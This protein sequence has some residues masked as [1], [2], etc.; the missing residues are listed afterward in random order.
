VKWK[1]IVAWIGGGIGVLILL[2]VCAAYLIQQNTFLHRY[3][4]GKMI[5]IARKSSGAEIQMRDYAIR[6]VPLHITL[7]DVSVRGTEKNPFRPLASLPRIE[8]GISWRALWHQNVDLTELILD[9]PTINLITDQSGNSNLPIRPA[10]SGPSTSKLQVSIEHAVVRNGELRYNDSPRKIDADLAEFHAGVSHSTGTD[11]YTG[12]LG[13]NRG[14]IAVDGYTPVRHATDLSF[15]ATNAGITFD[16]IHLSTGRSQLSVRGA[17]RGYSSPIVEGQYEALLSTADLRE[18][19][20]SLP[21]SGGEIDLAGSVSYRAVAGAPLNSLKLSGHVA[22]KTLMA[23]VSGTKVKFQSL[24]GNYALENGTLR[25]TGLQTETMGGTLRAELTGERLTGTPRYQL[26]LS[27]DSVSLEQAGQ[28]A[29]GTEFPLRG[30]VQLHANAHWTA[31]VATMM[32]RADARIS[33]TLNEPT[34]KA[35][36]PNATASQNATSLPVNA[37]VHVAYDAP[38]AT[39]TVT[40]SSFSSRQTSLIADGTVSDHSALSIRARTS[41]LREV[42]LLLSSAGDIQSAAAKTSPS[43]SNPLELRGRASLEAQIRGRIQDPRITGHAQADDIEVHRANWPH[44]ESNFEMTSASASL[45]NG[46]ARISNQGRLNFSLTTSLQNWSYSANNP[47]TAQIQASQVPLADVEQLAGSS[48]PVSGMLS[49]S[50]SVHGTLDDP[51][52]EGFIQLRDASLWGEPVR[53]VSAQIHAADKSLSATFNIATAAGNI[54]GNGEFGAA[55]RHYQISISHSVLNL[56]QIRYL[57]SHG[58]TM[59]GTLGIEAQGQGTLKSPELQAALTGD[60][61]ALGGTALGSLNAQFHVANERANFALTSNMAG[62]QIHAN[63]DAGLAAP[64][65][66]HG[67]FEIRSLQFGPLLAAYLPSI[68]RPFQGNAEVR[69]QID[70]PLADPGQ[71]KASVELSTL[72]LAYQDL[73]LASAG[74]VRFQYANDVVTISQAELRGTDTDFKF[75]GKLPL[76]GAA[77]LEI[78][79]SG[80]IDLRLLT[81]LGSNTQSSGTVKID[82]TAKGALKQPQLG[83]SIEIV[84]ASF[85][86]DVVPV[87]V[88]NLNARI[89]IAKSRLTIENLSGQMSGGSFSVSGFAGYSPAS[90]SLQVSGKSIRVRYPEGTR[91]QLDTNITLIGTPASSVLNGRVTVDGLSFTPDFDLAN[92]IGQFSSSTPSA[93]SQW[94]KNMRIDIAVV[95]SQELALSSSKLSLQGSADLRVA[96]TLANPV[97]LGR[98]ILSGGE[99]FFMGNRYQVQSG[100]VVFANPIRTEPTLNLYVTTQV[101]DYNITLNFLGPVDRLRTNYMSEPALP[102]VDIIHLLAFGKTTAQSAATATPAALGAESAI[103]NGLTSQVSSRIEKLAGISQL[104]I[105]PSLGGDNSNPGARVAIQQR[106][107]STIL[108]TFATDLTNTQNETV[109]MKYQTRG[110]LSLSLTRDEY[111]SYAIEAKIRKRF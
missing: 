76:S 49:A 12:N 42:E 110:R 111:G 1:K 30:T 67:G 56:A 39:L 77:P 9:R 71:V 14:Q 68:R 72:N 6:W 63:G 100:T 61:L 101:Q 41:D 105:D 99:L 29:G 25:V 16:R 36:E 74:P 10:P 54:N 11:R 109:Q 48:A 107:T 43:P 83:G 32:A 93:P 35:S 34:T 94:E 26:S 69:G 78:S 46:Q 22:S 88:D 106:L 20:R 92:F 65:M 95:S 31:T 3:L 40:N 85:T 108:F 5:Q 79:S 86:N 2:I 98:T 75:G 91:A 23:T 70:G 37:D 19:L 104:Q 64:Y 87:G 96:G 17:V 82:M 45:Q 90:F 24:A 59:A 7:E 33:A 84:K 102:P 44:I 47:G 58:Y 27:A 51:A 57:S 53:S 38:H 21:I 66:V 97:V 50:L 4:R 80:S 55:D 89:A 81:I 52:G 60:Q 8:M 103:A 15:T 13:Y 18:Q 28:T 73:S 62:G